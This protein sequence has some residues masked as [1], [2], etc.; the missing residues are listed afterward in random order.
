MGQ[1]RCTQSFAVGAP[2]TT[3]ARS[4]VEHLSRSGMVSNA[5][6]F[7]SASVSGGAPLYISEE[8]TSRMG[9]VV[10]CEFAYC[11]AWLEFRNCDM[12]A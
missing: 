10:M 2:G 1:R 9:L 7:L 3:G 5:I 8:T 12:R 4:H 11:T 6:P